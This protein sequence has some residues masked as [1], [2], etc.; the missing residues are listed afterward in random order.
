MTADGLS[1]QQL[2]TL[3]IAATFTAE[4]LEPSLR[5]WTEQLALPNRIEFA[6]Y[7]Q[8]FQQLLDPAS[9]LCANEGGVNIILIRLEDWAGQANGLT[10]DSNA[11]ACQERIERT[12]GDFLSALHTAAER[13]RVSFLVCLCPPAPNHT[14]TPE[15]AAFFKRVEEDLTAKI[16]DIPG[17]QVLG[18]AE[19]LDHYPVATYYD[20]EANSLAHVPY[21]ATFFA[22]LGT[23]IARR[24]HA[25]KNA[26]FK[27]IALDCDQTLWTGVCG[28]DGPQGVCIDSVSSALQEFMVERHNAGM[29]L[30]LCSKNNDNDVAE[31][32]DAHPEMPLKRDHIVAWRVNWNPKSENLQSLARELNL[33]LDSFIFIDDDPS[34][35]AEVEARCPEVLAVQLPRERESIP[36][37]LKHLWAF[38][39]SATTVEARHR[40][41]LYQQEVARK[42]FRESSLTFSDFLAGLNVQI[43]FSPLAPRHFDRAADLTWRTNQFNI[44]T[45]RRSESE[46][47]GFFRSN[48]EGLVVHVQDRFGDYGIVGLLLFKTAAKAIYV[49]T[50]LLSCRAIGRGV[51]HRMLAKLGEIA[52]ERGLDFV[53]IPFVPTPKNRPALEFLNSVGKGVKIPSAQ[54]LTYRFTARAASGHVY[55]PS[56]WDTGEPPGS[57]NPPQTRAG[58]ASGFDL[59]ARTALL[60]AIALELHDP[61]TIQSVVATQ[62]RLRP[63]ESKP[64]SLPET[65][66][67]KKVAALWSE[68]LGSSEIGRDDDFFSLGGHSLLAMQILSRLRAGF[69]VDLSPRLLYAGKFTVAG[70]SRAILLEQVRQGEPSDV[71]AILAE[72]DTLADE[73]VNGLLGNNGP[74][75]L[76]QK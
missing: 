39:Q 16:P 40:T 51:D 60:T 62:H 6:P 28:E 69:K 4:P 23:M 26:P 76:G 35:C 1:P 5:F 56:G 73:E 66:T 57:E 34:E 68:F 71:E 67:E 21:T 70:L 8:V 72:L 29:L 43:E 42:S 17:A 74:D 36:T 12:T 2:T 18:S 22:A 24:I 54:G 3:A 49:D 59:R 48:G 44:T 64:F 10:S 53:E 25:V 20:A 32:F 46:L 14:A 37:F 55:A 7:N 50:F 11:I 41:R 9:L 58:P 33:G 31:V 45:V 15:A 61:E 13:A 27:V 47:Q 52:I 63:D 30:C 19:L 38:D 75:P 65:E